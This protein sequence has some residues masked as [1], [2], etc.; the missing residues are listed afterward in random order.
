[1]ST[2]VIRKIDY[3][4]YPVNPYAKFVKNRPSRLVDLRRRVRRR[5]PENRRVEAVFLTD[6]RRYERIL[7]R[8]LR[9]ERRLN[10]RDERRIITADRRVD[11][12]AARRRLRQRKLTGR[13]RV[14]VSKGRVV[15]L[16]SGR[17]IGIEAE[18]RRDPPQKFSRVFRQ[19]DA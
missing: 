17:F 15:H 5:E 3:I 9:V 11:K 18:T 6:R 13:E 4:G 12:I 10:R 16:C 14:R 2:L 7:R 19:S 8:S 1:M